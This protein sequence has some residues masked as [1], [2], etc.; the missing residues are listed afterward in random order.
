M[1]ILIRYHTEQEFGQEGDAEKE[2]VPRHEKLLQAKH[3]FESLGMRAVEDH[4]LF[5]HFRVRHRH[6]PRDHSPPVMPAPKIKRSNK[7]RKMR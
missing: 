5:Q 3:S 6:F 2:K 7:K 1:I 4:K